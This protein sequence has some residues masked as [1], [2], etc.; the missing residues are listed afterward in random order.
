M[1]LCFICFCRKLQEVVVKPWSLESIS[2]LFFCGRSSF[3]EVWNGLCFLI[4]RL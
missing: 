2:Y 3:K 1:A 4:K